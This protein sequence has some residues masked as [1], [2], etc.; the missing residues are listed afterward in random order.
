MS[1]KWFF[2]LVVIILVTLILF[3]STGICQEM[4]EEG[5]YSI[6]FMDEQVGYEEFRWREVDQGY[7]LEVRGRITK[8]ISMQI[9]HLVIRVSKDF[10]PLSFEFEGIL[11][12]SKQSVSSSISDGTVKTTVRA[13]G[14][15]QESTVEIKRDAFL[16]PNP[17][18]SSYMFITKKYQCSL[19]EEKEGLSAYIIP[20]AETS[21]S[22]SP[23]EEEEC[24]L[25]MEIGA[26]VI[27]LET[28]ENGTLKSL[29]NPSQN[30]RV[31]LD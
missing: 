19:E 29:H 13:A 4:V 14:Q 25:L 3:T 23:S 1:K 6:Y 21:F 7:E 2:I 22:L 12:G 17:I 11:S 5:T 8:P 16:L 10:I 31:V 9:E 28:D 20:Q 18:F 30:I 27:E 24:V 26:A 15:E